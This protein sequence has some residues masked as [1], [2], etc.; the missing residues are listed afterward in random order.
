MQK[1][2]ALLRGINVGGHKKIKMVDL[3]SMFEKLK[4][5]AVTTYIQSGNVVFESEIADQHI[6]AET[7]KKGIKDTFD[8][9]V[10]V[11]VLSTDVLLSI[12]HANPFFTQLE[13]EE[14]DEKKMLFTFLDSLPDRSRI[15]EISAASHEKEKIEIRD[16]VI[17][18]YA[19][20]GYG[21]TK[22][23]NN[24]FEKKLNCSAT[25]RN[26][27]TVVKLLELSNLL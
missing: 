26:L 5:N 18:F 10:P 1:Y 25:T 4:F 2:I 17:Y 8:F 7:I 16:E 12:Y 9:D 14:L 20:N 22:L 15:H 6:I 19:G 13:N 23:S 21:K 11:L 3:T 24:F 27:K